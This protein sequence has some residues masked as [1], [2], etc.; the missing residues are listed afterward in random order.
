MK[1]I[2]PSTLRIVLF[3]AIILLTNN[4]LAQ[5]EVIYNESFTGQNDKGIS[6][7]SSNLGG[8]DWSIDVSNAHLL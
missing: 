7:S 5:S 3:T 8:V 1:K 6:G 4:V 2:L